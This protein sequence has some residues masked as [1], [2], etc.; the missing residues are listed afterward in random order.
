MYGLMLSM[1]LVRIILIYTPM[2]REATM[3][4]RQAALECKSETVVIDNLR[5]GIVS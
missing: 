3:S 2:D 5:P 4:I 1:K